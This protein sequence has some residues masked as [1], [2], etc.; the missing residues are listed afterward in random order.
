M[1]KQTPVPPDALF[2]ATVDVTRRYGLTWD[3]LRVSG[4]NCYRLGHRTVLWKVEDIERY[5][6]NTEAIAA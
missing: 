1:R 5:I 4:L 3:Y 6:A 2:L